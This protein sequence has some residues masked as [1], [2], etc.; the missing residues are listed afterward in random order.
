MS[1]IFDAEFKVGEWMRSSKGI[2]Y[3]VQKVVGVGGMG[4]VYQVIPEEEFGGRKYALK[5]ILP[6]LSRSK[7]NVDRFESEGRVVSRFEHHNII[8][9]EGILYL[10][11]SEPR[12]PMILMELLEGYTLRYLI[13]DYPETFPIYD[14]CSIAVGVSNALTYIHDRNVIHRDIKPENIY[15]DKKDGKPSRVVLLDFGIMRNVLKAELPGPGGGNQTAGHF[16]GTYANASPEQLLGHAVTPKSDLYSLGTVLYEMITRK[17]LFPDL[18][19]SHAIG[20]AHIMRKPVS[21]HVIAPDLPRELSS[22]IMQAL[23]KNP[24]DRPKDAYNFVAPFNKIWHKMFMERAAHAGNSTIERMFKNT[25][26][27]DHW[28]AGSSAA[29]GGPSP[30][31]ATV[32]MEPLRADEADAVR[33]GLNESAFLP[34]T[35]EAPIHSGAASERFDASALMPSSAAYPPY[36]TSRAA[37][38]IE[39]L[40]VGAAT[41]LSGT[42]GTDPTSTQ[43]VGRPN[44]PDSRVRDQSSPG[45]REV[46]ARPRLGG[47]VVAAIAACSLAG[48][49]VFFTRESPRS[50]VSTSAQAKP[51]T[52][53]ASFGSPTAGTAAGHV[54][55]VLPSDPVAADSPALPIAAPFDGPRTLTPAATVSDAGKPPARHSKPRSAPAPSAKPAAD[56]DLDLFREIR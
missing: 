48:G 42:P 45:V 39:S 21:L 34:R 52:A 17:P 47:F 41:A 9:I 51:Q 32:R 19:E 1:E 54:P 10:A 6:E 25:V 28:P 2:N 3:E 13:D 31:G 43:N 30:K 7:A 23:E 40:P 33:R 15:I 49:Y 55:A 8:R 4:M 53:E 46:P 14:V 29:S 27:G 5:L 12:R 20:Q 38:G 36:G 18:T 26:G 37:E 50:G 35:L 16:V 22:M 44:Q 24:E 56:P 11:G